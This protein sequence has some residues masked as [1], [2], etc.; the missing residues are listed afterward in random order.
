[1]L[2]IE[3]YNKKDREIKKSCRKDKRDQMEEMASKLEAA[4]ERRDLGKLYDISRCLSEKKN[5]QKKKPLRGRDDKLISKTEEQLERT[6]P[7]S[8]Q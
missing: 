2:E 4:A 6:L 5:F 7:R 8:S 1:M 3:K